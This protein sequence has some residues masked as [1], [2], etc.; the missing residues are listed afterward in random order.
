MQPCSCLEA[1]TLDGTLFEPSGIISGGRQDLSE[2]VKQ[3]DASSQAA[4]T[5]QR[6]ER[7]LNL[8]KELDDLTK[9]IVRR[10]CSISTVDMKITSLKKMIDLAMNQGRL[11]VRQYSM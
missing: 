3:W 7:K 8:E 5:R 1:V 10:D 2:K 6:T 9:S 4:A 11:D